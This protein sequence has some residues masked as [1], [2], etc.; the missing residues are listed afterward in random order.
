LGVGDLDEEA[1]GIVRQWIREARRP[2]RPQGLARVFILVLLKSSG[3]AAVPRAGSLRRR[4]G[5]RGLLSHVG[6]PEPQ[7]QCAHEERQGTSCYSMAAHHASPF[8]LERALRQSKKRRP[9]RRSSSL[10]NFP[11]PYSPV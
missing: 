9:Q 3:A 5:G 11:A 7:N 4:G 6:P 2:Q 1:L 8:L 10:L